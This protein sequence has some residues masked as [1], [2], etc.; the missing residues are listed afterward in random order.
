[1]VDRPKTR[2]AANSASF[3]GV[4]VWNASQLIT[5]SLKALHDFGAVV[6]EHRTLILPMSCPA[7]A[8]G[9]ETFIDAQA[10]TSCCEA[11]AKPHSGASTRGHAHGLALDRAERRHRG[12][13]KDYCRCCRCA[14]PDL[15]LGSRRAFGGIVSAAARP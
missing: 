1:M 8:L 5:L 2:I 15:S 7:T 9:V 3:A 10:W 4:G 12:R 11:M 14:L 13:R 6:V